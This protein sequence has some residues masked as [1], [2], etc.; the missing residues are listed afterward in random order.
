MICN[1]QLFHPEYDG[2]AP[3]SGSCHTK[4]QRHSQKL[5]TIQPAFLIFILITDEWWMHFI[6]KLLLLN[7]LKLK[8]EQ[9]INKFCPMSS[10]TGKPLIF[11]YDNLLLAEKKTHFK[12]VISNLLD[13]QEELAHIFHQMSLVS[14]WQLIFRT[15]YRCIDDI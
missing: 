11:K 6:N 2:L 10:R 13:I 4:T 14:F 15:A 5:G 1:Q 12:T 8:M 7:Y 9:F 3:P